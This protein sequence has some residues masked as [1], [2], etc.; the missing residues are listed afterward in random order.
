L[1]LGLYSFITN[2]GIRQ[3]IQKLFSL[4]SFIIVVPNWVGCVVGK[5]RYIGN[6]QLAY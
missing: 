4:A 5:S 2:S 3:R 6:G 1:V